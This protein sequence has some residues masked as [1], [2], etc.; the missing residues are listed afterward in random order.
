MSY[1]LIGIVIIIALGCAWGDWTNYRERSHRLDTT[2]KMSE[3]ET[4]RMKDF[5]AAMTT[6]H[7]PEI[8]MKSF[9]DD[10]DD[11]RRALDLLERLD[12]LPIADAQRILQLAERWL[13][14][15]H[16]VDVAN[17]EFMKARAERPP[18]SGEGVNH[19]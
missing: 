15:T 16:R 17:A 9:L 19:A 13:C 4:R 18:F 2:V 11:D 12:G 3:Q 6:N 10:H 1:G 8:C 14:S 7:H 5:I